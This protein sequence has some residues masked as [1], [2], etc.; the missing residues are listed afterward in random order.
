MKTKY[1]F[2]KYI[3]SNSYKIYEVDKE[4]GFIKRNYLSNITVA[5]LN[6]KRFIY[7]EKGFFDKQTEIINSDNKIVGK[8]NYSSW[9]KKAFLRLYGNEVNW[10]YTNVW[11]TRWNIEIP[12]EKKIE[13]CSNGNITNDK[14]NDNELEILSSIYI[15]N[16]YRRAMITALFI[17]LTPTF[18]TRIFS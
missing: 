2:K 17:I 13:F 10:K 14:I 11:N 18:L 4:I 8:I 5:E 16:Y 7:K 12:N 9:N 15:F 1:N 3:F 6:E